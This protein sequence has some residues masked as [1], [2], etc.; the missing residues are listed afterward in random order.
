MSERRTNDRYSPSFDDLRD[1]VAKV[2]GD[3]N[4]TTM[5]TVDHLGRPRSRPLIAVWELEPEAP[6]GWLA[7][8]KTPVKSA[9]IARNPHVTTSYW[10][11]R[12]DFASLDSVARW[13]DDPEVK[14]LVWRLYERGSPAGVGYNPAGFWRGP[15]DPRFQV[16]RFDPWRIQ[17]HPA[18]DLVRGIRS[19]IWLA[20]DR[21]RRTDNAQ[22]ERLETGNRAMVS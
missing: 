18:R 20:P 8:F 13:V 1:D 9:H 16:L 21:A 2:M 5:T 17:V 3:A 7:T 6:V 12:N 15:Q 19:P 14:E 22:P 11:P 10:S 4:Y